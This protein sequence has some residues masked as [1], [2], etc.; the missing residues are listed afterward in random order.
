MAVCQ[1]TEQTLEPSIRALRLESDLLS[2]TILLDK[3]ADICE[4]IY[5]PQNLDE[6]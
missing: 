6:L 1:I 2:T 5:K 4:L 3:G